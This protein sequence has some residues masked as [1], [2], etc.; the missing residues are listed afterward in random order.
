[1][2]DAGLDRAVAPGYIVTGLASLQTRAFAVTERASPVWPRFACG[3]ELSSD[4]LNLFFGDLV[5]AAL[6]S[7]ELETIATAFHR[8]H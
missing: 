2:L 1:L 3:A 6:G 4:F 7:N 5:G 8:C